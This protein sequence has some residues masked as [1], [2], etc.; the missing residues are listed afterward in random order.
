MIYKQLIQD[1]LTHTKRWSSGNKQMPEEVSSH[2]YID[3]KINK[4]LV[5][6][7]FTLP[8]NDTNEASTV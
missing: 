7:S 8:Q 4:V 2:N 1:V 6:Q 3:D 5:T